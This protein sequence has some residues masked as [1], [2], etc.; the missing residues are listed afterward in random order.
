MPT[1]SSGKDHQIIFGQIYFRS[2]LRGV[3]CVLSQ[4]V[5][6]LI[7]LLSFFLLFLETFALLTQK[8]WY[9]DVTETS[10]VYCS[11]DFF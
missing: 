10:H 3:I 9:L 5:S 2:H 8:H 1:E 7:F 4:S 11:T 6:P